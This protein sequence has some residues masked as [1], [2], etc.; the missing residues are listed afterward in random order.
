MIGKWIK[1]SQIIGRREEIVKNIGSLS[2][3]KT[4]LQSVVD[5][6]QQK[7]KESE[8]LWKKQERKSIQ[9]ESR[10]KEIANQEKEIAQR[11]TK[12]SDFEQQSKMFEQKLKSSQEQIA[13]NQKLA[14]EA[15]KRADAEK[16]KEKQTHE[17]ISKLQDRSNKLSDE[18]RID[19]ERRDKI[20]EEIGQRI[21]LNKAEITRLNGE[22]SRLKQARENLISETNHLTTVV[23]QIELEKNDAIQWR[24][25]AEKER[26][27]AIDL[28]MV[29][30]QLASNAIIAKVT[31]SKELVNLKM[32]TSNLVSQLKEKEARKLAL[33]TEN[34]AAEKELQTKEAKAKLI[35]KE[36]E[37]LAGA[38]LTYQNLTVATNLLSG[39]ITSVKTEMSHL[40]NEQKRLTS[41]V[42]KLRQIQK[43][44][45]VQIDK[46][47]TDIIS[48]TKGKNNNKK[49]TD[50]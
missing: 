1:D 49:G 11:E 47:T 12:L 15:Q 44:L 27:T 32:A 4:S 8:A 36:I 19:E 42:A 43:Q 9:L 37:Y 20:D 35:A 17:A 24:D 39:K 25:Q 28:Y 40:Q 31:A 21:E 10:E 48:S 26:K 41:S 7:Q 46:I 2:E 29:S 16:Q 30:S 3:Q 34:A 33:E 50:K 14:D 6:L 18:I 45:H 5:Q 38:H 23:T 13:I 22:I